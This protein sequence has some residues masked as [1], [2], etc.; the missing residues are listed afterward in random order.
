M[1]INDRIRLAIEAREL[2]LKEA[3]KVC[4]LS[5][6]SLQNWV[7][8]IREPRPEALI[9]LGS[10]LGIS[11]DWL[12]TGEGPMLRGGAHTDSNNDQT[13]SPQEKAILALYRSLGE[14][15]QR[16]IQSAAEE[17]KRMR[18]IEQRLEELTTALADVKKHA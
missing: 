18:D 10:H 3:A 15:D 12:L 6:S 8:G 2:S 16:D 17:K 5:Y 1:G 14:S 7:G 11:I 4:S 9:A 13:T